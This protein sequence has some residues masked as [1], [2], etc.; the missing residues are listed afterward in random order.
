MLEHMPADAQHHRPVPANQ[1]GERS[2]VPP[3]SELLEQVSIGALRARRCVGLLPKVLHNGTEMGTGHSSRLLRRTPVSQSS[4]LRAEKRPVFLVS[5]TSPSPAG[6][7]RRN[8]E[9]GNP[10]ADNSYV[11]GGPFFPRPRFG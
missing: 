1:R 6:I 10:A 4:S 3:S 7:R 5:R 8:K 9:P 2:C 11:L